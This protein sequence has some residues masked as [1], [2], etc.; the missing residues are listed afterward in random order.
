MKLRQLYEAPSSGWAGDVF[1]RFY[2][3]DEPEAPAERPS[4]FSSHTG[5]PRN[6]AKPG[7]VRKAMNFFMGKGLTREQAAGVVGNL[8]A[9]SGI[10]LNSNAI[11]D[12]GRAKGIAQWHPDRRANFERWKGIPFDNSTF[13]DQLQFIWWEF[14]NTERNAYRRLLRTTTA[15]EAAQIIDQYYER[16][17][18][19]HRQKRIELASALA[20]MENRYL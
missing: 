2:D 8:Q 12:G 1:G 15:E 19:Q 9:E 3:K 11:G 16:S 18:G 7:N 6:S 20:D 17:S 14:T 4:A 5:I 10:R 13:E